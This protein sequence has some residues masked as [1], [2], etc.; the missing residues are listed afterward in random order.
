M[1][2]FFKSNIQ[3]YIEKKSKVENEIAVLK[4]QQ[5]VKYETVVADYESRKTQFENDVSA[6]IASLKNQIKNLEVA[7][8]TQADAYEKEKVVQLKLVDNEFDAKI[9]T[10]QNEVKKLNN[11]IEKEQKDMEDI[12]EPIKPNAPKDNRKI[13]VE[14][15][16]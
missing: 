13:I 6:Q 14:T 7:K 16:K 3:R 11:L 2:K 10:K 4:T 8:T 12:I 5:K 15:K 9:L 1:F